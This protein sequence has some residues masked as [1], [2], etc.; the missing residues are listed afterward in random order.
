MSPRL[1]RR[2]ARGAEYD[3]AAR[4]R[5]QS[6]P[7]LAVPEDEETLELVHDR[8][9]H[10]ALWSAATATSSSCVYASIIDYYSLLTMLY[11]YSIF[12]EAF[13]V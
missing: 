11:P 13:Y 10:R 1:S 12:L 4:A 5:D 9:L 6:G 7:E 8:L 3:A 2:A